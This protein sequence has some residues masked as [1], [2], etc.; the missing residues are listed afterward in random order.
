M[1]STYL[2]HKLI[3]DLEEESENQSFFFSE[4]ACRQARRLVNENYCQVFRWTKKEDIFNVKVLVFP[5]NM[6]SHWFAVL[7]VDPA[8]LLEGK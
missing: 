5:I 6:F 7:V 2:L 4:E 1:F 8:N 3:S